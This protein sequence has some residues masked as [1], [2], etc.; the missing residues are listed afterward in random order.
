MK[1]LI[2]GNGEIG[3]SLLGVL[4]SHYSCDIIDK[5]IEDEPNSRYEIMHICFPYSKEFDVSVKGY[6][7]KYQPKY[8]V[9]HSTVPVGVSKSLGAIHSPC[10]GI[11]PHLN[12]SLT[13]FTKFLGGKDASNVAQYFRRAGIKVYLTDDSNAT[14]LMKVMSTT[15]YGMCI[16]YTKEVKRQ[17]D[18]FGIPFELW[19]IWTNNYNN[20]YVS[21]GYPEYVRPN[22]VPIMTKIGGHC[23]Q[24]N[25][26]LL[27]EGCGDTSNIKKIT[28]LI[29]MGGSMSNE[30]NKLNDRVWLYCE[31][32]G[33]GKSMKKI[34]DELGCS[35]VTV[36]KYMKKHNIKTRNRKFNNNEIKKILKLHTEGKTFKEISNIMENDYDKIRNHIY[37]NTNIK[38]NYSPGEETKK[39]NIRK[40]ISSKLQGIT[41]DEW[42]GFKETEN[43]LIR[44][45]EKYKK[46]RMLVFER[47]GYVCQS[48]NC[49]FCGNRYG[50]I[51]LNAHHIKSFSKYLELRFDINNGITYCENYHLKSGIHE[52]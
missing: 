32:W 43:S 37:K 51:K 29:M 35:G 31:Y 47:D 17:C 36:G 40:K 42:N 23:T 39:E 30:E 52:K 3:K 15:Y 46:W 25:C 2:I 20:G 4:D 41:E 44:K 5:V 1:T 6:Q 7:N 49:K 18:K 19:S 45:S 10:I 8:I 16:E 28:E 13:T 21:L 38:S 24:S 22:L 26:I 14:E 27:H 34:G 33:K 11:H 12:E 48:T 50:G 9:I